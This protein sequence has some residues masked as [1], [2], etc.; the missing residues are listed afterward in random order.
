MK[1]KCTEAESIQPKSP[2]AGRCFTVHELIPLSFQRKLKLSSY[3]ASSTPSNCADM[4]FHYQLPMY[5][6]PMRKI[7]YFKLTRTSHLICTHLS[8]PSRCVALRFQCISILIFRSLAKDYSALLEVFLSTSLTSSIPYSCI[9]D[10]HSL[11]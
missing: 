10:F 11:F 1:S 8:T 6:L 9:S 3:V 2:G 5:N 4:S 7:L